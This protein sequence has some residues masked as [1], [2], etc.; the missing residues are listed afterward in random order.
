MIQEAIKKTK[1]KPEIILLDWKGLGNSEQKQ[2]ITKLLN[3]QGLKYK[4]TSEIEK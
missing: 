2:E 4:R 1:E 3:S